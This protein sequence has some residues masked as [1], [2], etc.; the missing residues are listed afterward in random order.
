MNTLFFSRIGLFLYAFLL[1][2]KANGQ[3]GDALVD[4]LKQE[5]RKSKADTNQVKLLMDLGNNVGYY[6]APAALKYAQQGLDLSKKINYRLG[7]ARTHYLLG[8]TYIDLGNYAR[9]QTHLDAAARLFSALK[10]QD[11][12]GKIE[13]ARGNWHYLQSDLWNAAHHYGQAVEIFHAL[14]DTAL[15]IIPYQNLIAALGETKNHEKAIT[16]SKRLLEIVKKRG[17]SLQMAYSYNYLINNYVALNQLD[18]AK[19]YVA[20]LLGFIQKSMDYGLAADAYNVIGGYHYKKLEYQ[21]ALAHYHQA[22]EKALRSDY[23]TAQYKHSIGQTYLQLNEPLK[24]YPYLRQA[25][26]EAQAANSKDVY[27]QVCRSL[28][29]Y[30]EKMGDYQRAYHYLQEYN[31]LNDSILV[32]ETRH[33]TTYLEA[34]FENSKKE[35]EI[36][37]LKTAELQKDLTL[38]KRNNYLLVALSFLALGGIFFGLKVRNDQTRRKLLEQDKKLQAEKILSLEKEQQVISLQSM[39][40]GQESERNRIAKDLHDGL[41]G[42]FSTVK[43]Y[44]SSL[45]HEQPPL[46]ENPLFQKSMELTN[47][48]SLELRRIAHNLMPEVLMKLGLINAI[49]DLCNNINTSR[50][51]TI[52]LQ[53]Y[54]MEKRLNPNTEIM[55]YRIVQELLNNII[56]H[57]Q[58]SEAIIQFN[59]HQE[60]LNITIEDNGLGFNAS[61]DNAGA[62]LSTIKSRVNYLNGALNIDS[63]QGVGTTVMMEFLLES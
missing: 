30:C 6:D 12:L 5:L 38:K 17:D 62:G 51:L 9:S 1:I 23:Q 21:Q 22:L 29:E 26:T 15:E 48:A 55:L 54:G 63:T 32:A 45:Q 53:A 13:N 36:F 3:A 44:F 46:G 10:R 60:R 43:M 34:A 4:S 24:A 40:T 7:Q 28:G 41:G 39:I 52:S 16:M 35:T 49:Q 8:N 19:M 58:A 42:L 14:K 33:Y 59:Q 27:Y 47:T 18:A 31:K 50:L 61:E 2:I 37:R 57:A 25:E 56:K 11:M 20:D